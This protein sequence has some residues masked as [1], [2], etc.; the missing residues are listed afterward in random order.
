MPKILQI[1]AGPNGCG[2]STIAELLKAEGLLT[3][4]MN[5]DIIAQG[6]SLQTSQLS[7][8]QAGRAMLE[9]LH[10]A[11]RTGESVSFET[12]LSGRSWLRLI[13]DAHKNGY[14]VSLFYVLVRSVDI[15]LARVAQR[16]SEGGHHIPDDTVRRRFERSKVLFTE[17]YRSQVDEWFLF[18][19]SESKSALVVKGSGNAQT[20]FSPSLLVEL[21]L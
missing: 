4:F 8:I 19:N 9:R 10:T 1:I 2:K 21:N 6:L 15:A 16:V 3:P 14:V 11:I 5:A 13:S 18:D 20:I 12:T 7:E 17:M